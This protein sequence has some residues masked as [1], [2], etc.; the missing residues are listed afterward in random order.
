MANTQPTDLQHELLLAESFL[1]LGVA[2]GREFELEL[3]PHGEVLRLGLLQLLQLRQE[4]HVLRGL[5]RL[6]LAQLQHQ[7]VQ[8]LPVRVRRLQNLREL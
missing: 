2:R 4:L 8:L 6:S 5:L 3:L 1:G 7:L